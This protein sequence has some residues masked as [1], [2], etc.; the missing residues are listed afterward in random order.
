MSAIYRPWRI[1]EP[2]FLPPSVNDYVPPGH[3]AHFVRDMVRETLDLSAFHAAHSGGRGQ[4]PF[5]PRLM[6]ALLIYCYSQG[7]YSSR[8][9]A[10]A[11][12]ERLDVMAIT[13][14]EAPDF[15][16]IALFR[17][18]HLAALAA[19]FGQ[20]LQLCRKA[21]LVSLG[22]VALD[23]TKVLA[24][25]SKR[26]AMSY[27]RMKEKEPE[28][29]DA[30]EEAATPDRRGD[31]M[32]D[33]VADKAARL[34]KIRA[35]KA[36]LEAE[37]SAAAKAKEKGGDDPPPPP[38]D[39]AQRNFTD[40]ES[41]IMRTG[42]GFEQAY[43]AQA[44]VDA[45]HQIVVACEVGTNGVDVGRL[46]PMLDAME[47]DG[48][49]PKQLSADA[50]YCSEANLAA[51]DERGVDGYVA[52][53]RQRHG[54][55]PGEGGKS[56]RPLAEAMR[57]KLRAGGFEGPY[58]KRKITV[59]PVFGQIKEARGFRRFLM[60]GLAKVRGEWSFLCAVHNVLKLQRSRP[61]F[62]GL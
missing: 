34:E 47:A 46:V 25:A 30:A 51:L 1:D 22:H 2:Q 41:R 32:P 11:C 43:N 40:P 56:K 21:G 8:R 18:R 27:G 20:V 42:D 3:A 23:G 10:R 60:R 37:A 9:I 28:F 29:A 55:P 48:V 7:V 24:N 13:A 33:W 12:E 45:D 44:A 15:R 49:L 36:A 61:A 39:K 26:K 5:D 50:G 53:G 14:G 17:S 4:P 19:L 35:A 54:K 62:V 6:V 38:D 31:E 52:A 16:T 58:R 57:E 59:E